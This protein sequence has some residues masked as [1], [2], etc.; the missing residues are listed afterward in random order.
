[1]RDA[2][3]EQFAEQSPIRRTSF[4]QF[5]LSTRS[6]FANDWAAAQAGNT[7]LKVKLS[8]DLL[9]YWMQA[10]GL[11]IR[12][13]S[14]IPWVKDET[15]NPQPTKVWSAV[16]PLSQAGIDGNGVGVADLGVIGVDVDDVLILLDVGRV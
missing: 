3:L 15:Q 11:V 10:L 16:P 5:L 4:P 13:I 6:D 12:G 1:M 14:T 8:L 7:R 9:P 2:A